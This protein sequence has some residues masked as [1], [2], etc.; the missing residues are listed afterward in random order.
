MLWLGDRM[1]DAATVPYGGIGGYNYPIPYVISQLTGSYQEVPDFLDSQHKIETSAD[2]EAYVARLEAFAAN[3][4]LEVDRARADA[5][6]GV[7]PPGFIL[8][9][10][11]TQTRT[12][13]AERGAQAGLVRSL[14]RRAAREGHRR[15]LGDPGGGDRRR[16]PR[17]RA[18][19]PAR[20]C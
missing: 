5:G 14:V 12:L 11:L 20:A 7:V 19:P 13:R 2:A 15:R 1:A 3:I 6:R 9:K 17:R 16:P 8:D 10:A 4:N 18:R